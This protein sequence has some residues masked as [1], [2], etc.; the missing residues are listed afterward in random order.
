MKR[1]ALVITIAIAAAVWAQGAPTL[2]PVPDFIGGGVCTLSWNPITSTTPS[3]YQIQVLRAPEGTSTFPS[4]LD[5]MPCGD[6]VYSICPIPAG[7][8]PDNYFVIGRDGTASEADNPLLGG[9]R[10]CFRMRYRY[11]DGE[12]F[13]WSPYSAAMCS[14]QDNTP[15]VVTVTALA[16]WTNTANVT[17]SFTAEDDHTD[18]DSVVLYYRTDSTSAW[19]EVLR[20]PYIVGETPNDVVFN[21]ADFEGDRYYEF[22]I[23][24]KDELG[25]TGSILDG[26]TPK[27][28][29]TWTR[30]DTH[31]PEA[32]ITESS[33]TDYYTSRFVPF[34]YTGSD[35]YSGM[36]TVRIKY[37]RNGG[38]VTEYPPAAIFAGV[39]TISVTDTFI[40]AADGTFEVFAEAEDS[41]GNIELFT[42]YE[43]TFHIDT[44]LPEFSSTTTLDTTT[45]SHREDVR[46]EATWTN[47]RGIFVTP[48]AAT[49]PASDAY[50]SGIESVYVAEGEGFETDDNVQVFAYA[51][52]GNYLYNLTTDDGEKNVFVRLKDVAGNIS[53][54]NSHNIKLDTDAPT[55]GSTVLFDRTSDISTDETDELQVR[56]VVNVPPTSSSF[57]KVFLTQNRTQLNNIPDAAWRDLTDPL[58]F[59]CADAPSGSWLTV[60]AVV[61]DSAGN[62]SNDVVDS[63]RYVP[64]IKFLELMSIRDYNGPDVTGTYTNDTQVELTVRYGR[65]IDSIRVWD[66]H[67]WDTTYAAAEVEGVEGLDTIMHIFSSGDGVRTI[68]AQGWRNLD[69]VPTSPSSRTI[70]LDQIR[71]VLYPVRVIDIST[72]YDPG[73]TS[74]PSD[75][76][77]SNKANVRVEFERTGVPHDER[78]GIRNYRITCDTIITVGGYIA[79]T[80]FTVPNTNAIWSVACEIQDSAGNWSLPQTFN[81]TL[82]KYRPTIAGVVL[83][84]ASSLDST[85]TDERTIVIDVNAADDPTGITDPAYVAFFEN[86]SQWPNN[87][88]TLW[89]PYSPTGMS[90]TFATATEEMKTVYAAVKDHAGNISLHSSARIMFTTQTVISFE[91]YDLDRGNRTYT[92]SRNVGVRFTTVGT[93][94]AD[95]FLSELPDAAPSW[96]PLTD[97]VIY[98]VTGEEGENTVFGWIRSISYTVSA[99]AQDDIIVDLHM[100]NVTYGFQLYDT[101]TADSWNRKIFRAHVGWSN[102][103]FVYGYI[104]EALDT[105][106]GVDSLHFAGPFADSIW[107]DFYRYNYSDGAVSLGYPQDSVRLVLRDT[108]GSFDIVGGAM[109]GAGNWND[110][111]LHG[112]YDSEAPYMNLLPFNHSDPTTM[113]ARIPVSITDGPDGG[114]LWKVCFKDSATAKLACSEYDASWGTYPEF[115]VVFPLADSLNPEELHVIEV[116]AVDSAGNA[117]EPRIWRPWS[118]VAFTVVATNDTFDSDFSRSKVV[119]TKIDV[120]DETPDSMRFGETMAQLNAAAWKTFAHIDTFTF[121]NSANQQKFVYGQVKLGSFISPVNIDSI[122][123]DTIAPTVTDVRAQDVETGDPNWSSQQRLQ[124][125]A[126]D[127]RDTPPGV[128]YAVL[129]SES[130]NFDYNAQVCTLSTDNTAFYTVADVP[131]QPQP[132]DTSILADALNQGRRMLFCKVLDRAEN[133]ARLKTPSIVV[134]WDEIEVMNFPN[135]FNPNKRPTYIRIQSKVAGA[136]IKVNIYDMFGNPVWDTEVDLSSGSRL[137]DI[138]WDGKNSDGD[139]VGNGG[140]ICIVDVD[141]KTAKR[142]I[143]VWKGED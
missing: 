20:E 87:L 35:T 116:V 16:N 61:K 113:P 98:Y 92:N 57:Y 13:T 29:H 112:G 99:R 48:V 54:H 86:A 46:A 26:T 78:T 71:P 137:G 126:I 7:D 50:A 64:G 120:V 8:V 110:I 5:T 139:V 45:A 89:R 18:V 44:R 25:N 122:V 81:L 55:L 131:Y 83:R 22:Y 51:P 15:P 75:A 80:P 32:L 90:Y 115:N 100:P 125:V 67:G 34:A 127:P 84:D 68:T 63:I 79:A 73:D 3:A 27:P 66:D 12:S 96:L 14:Q 21:S 53:A 58:Y 109:D 23:T 6:L 101:T 38:A 91:L 93:P 136:H 85:Y 60:Y 11:N 59:T 70:I 128:V 62:V 108:P 2:L 1:L 105:L 72:A 111:V 28:H 130:P 69:P 141:G 76:G 37:S 134:Y 106:S 123:V 95:Y 36:R 17:I 65:D 114:H 97:T 9:L 119:L 24:A 107:G 19:E 77:Y 42:D 103:R 33:V 56:V 49:D 124:I 132:G 133:A 121:S 135:P 117:S 47:S 10:Y 74:E 138:S 82:D 39:P 52:A 140:Y 104:K 94:P 102:E 41:A 118:K 40:P 31:K 143:A 142:K 43:V 4:H 88:S 30:V 129:V